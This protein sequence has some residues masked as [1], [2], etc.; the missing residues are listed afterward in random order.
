MNNNKL[1]RKLEIVP[2]EKK[3]Y[4]GN[5]FVGFLACTLILALII[6]FIYYLQSKGIIDITKILAWKI[7]I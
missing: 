6:G 3:E 1:N 4:K 5:T 7:I 2:G